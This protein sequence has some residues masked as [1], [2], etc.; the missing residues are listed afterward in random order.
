MHIINLIVFAL[1]LAFVLSP[2]SA[3]GQYEPLCAK[4]EHAI[5]EQLK[6]SKVYRNDA[7]SYGCDIEYSLP[8]LMVSLEIYKRLKKTQTEFYKTVRMFRTDVVGEPLDPVENVEPRGI[9]N[10]TLLIPSKKPGNS[11]VML[12]LHDNY[13][14]TLLSDNR[15]LLFEIEKVLHS[16]KLFQQLTE[17]H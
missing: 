10:R 5:S 9:W 7:A 6:D 12:L 17:R 13:F 14:I 4:I 16:D 2:R 15:E 11:H 1:A 8:D 3:F